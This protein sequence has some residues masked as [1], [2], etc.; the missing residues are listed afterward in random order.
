VASGSGVRALIDLFADF[1]LVDLLIRRE[2]EERGVPSYSLGLLVVIEELGPITPTALAVETG[3][4]PTTLRRWL[5]ELA[6]RRLVTRGANP[7]DGRSFTVTITKT[8]RQ[9]LEAATPA[10]QATVAAIEEHLDWHVGDELERPLAELKAALQQ[11]LGYG[12]AI[13]PDDRRRF[14][15]DEE[16]PRTG[17]SR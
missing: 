16:P 13:G 17:R 12:A 6:R 10:L 4:P 9:S 11:A 15:V 1:H 5:D 3:L 14:W 2:L 7:A 8:G